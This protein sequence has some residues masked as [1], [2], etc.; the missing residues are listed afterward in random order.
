MANWFNPV[1]DID[2]VA[3][4][5]YPATLGDFNAA[6]KELKQDEVLLCFG[7]RGLF[8]QAMHAE[9]KELFDEY[10]GQYR[11]GYITEFATYALPRSIW[12]Q[13]PTV[14]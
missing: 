5:I 3:R 4:R 6:M 13:G 1:A 9:T 2:D 12:E 8:K 14:G 7:N 11:D 10:F